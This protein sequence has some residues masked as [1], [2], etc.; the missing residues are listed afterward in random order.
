MLFGAPDFSNP[1][2]YVSDGD[3]L[4]VPNPGFEG[5]VSTIEYS[6]SVRINSKGHRGPELGAKAPGELRLLALGDS[7]TLGVQVEEEQTT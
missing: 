7:F 3:L 6:A 2:L 5:E 1:D 4:L